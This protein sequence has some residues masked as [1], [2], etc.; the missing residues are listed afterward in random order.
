MQGA[1]DVLLSF[2]HQCHPNE[3]NFFKK[4]KL[5]SS[6]NKSSAVTLQNVLPNFQNKKKAQNI[7][8]IHKARGK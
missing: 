1:D 5:L 2:I 8:I 6:I 4:I 3:L 7:D